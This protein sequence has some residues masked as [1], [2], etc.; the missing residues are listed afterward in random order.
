LFYQNLLGITKANKTWGN[1][2]KYHSKQTGL[3]VK[4]RVCSENVQKCKQSYL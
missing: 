4:G 1:K 2:A 3:R